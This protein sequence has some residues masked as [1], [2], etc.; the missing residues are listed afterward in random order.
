MKRKEFYLSPNAVSMI[1]Q[2]ESIICSSG[3]RTNY[4]PDDSWSDENYNTG[5]G[6]DNYDP[7]TW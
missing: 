6:R 5:S 3:G 1:L 2:Q 7:D 4:D